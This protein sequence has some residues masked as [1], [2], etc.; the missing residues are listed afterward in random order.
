MDTTNVTE[1]LLR[2]ILELIAKCETV[3]KKLAEA[4]EKIADLEKA[5]EATDAQRDKL[6]QQIDAL[7]R[8]ILADDDLTDCMALV[9]FQRNEIDEKIKSAAASI[10]RY[11][12]NPSSPDFQQAVKDHRSLDGEQAYYYNLAARLEAVKQAGA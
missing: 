8:R 1:A 9:D 3:E 5:L 11:A 7:S 2:A 6:H 12:D 4:E 10:V